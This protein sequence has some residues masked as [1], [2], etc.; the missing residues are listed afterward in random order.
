MIELTSPRG[1]ASAEL[2]GRVAWRRR[3]ATGWFVGVRVYEDE[4]D[5]RL[6]L[7]ELICAGL[8]SQAGVSGLR[9]RQRVLVDLQLA[10]RP[11]ESAASI[12]N[13]L[14]PAGHWTGARAMVLRF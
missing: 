4:A 11:D 8:K 5:V 6:V 2:K 10:S 9:G 3:S 14:V 1:G 12:W 13:R 7:A